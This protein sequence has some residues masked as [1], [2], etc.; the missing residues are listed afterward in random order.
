M[1]KKRSRLVEPSK[2]RGKRKYQ[3]LYVDTNVEDFYDCGFDNGYNLVAKMGSS[4]EAY[5]AGYE[6]GYTCRA[7]ED[8]DKKVY[9]LNAPVFTY[10]GDHV[11]V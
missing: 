6:D 8:L 2:Y 7:L 3:E 10:R 4:V 1:S 9:E 5:H 11:R